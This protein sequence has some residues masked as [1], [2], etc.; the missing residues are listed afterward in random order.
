MAMYFMINS[1]K[2]ISSVYL[3]KW[4]GTSQ[5]TAWK[6]GH[7]VRAIMASQADA[8]PGLAGIV[9]LDEKYLGGKPRYQKDIKHK[10]GRGTAKSCV[11]VA[12]NRDGQVRASVVANDSYAELAPRVNRFIDTTAGLMSDQ[13]PVY[14][15]VA[16]DYA[17][18]ASVNHGAKEFVNGDVHNNTAESFNAILERVK[19]GVFH[20]LSK[21]H[22]QRYISEVVFRWNHRYPAKEISKNGV[23]KIIYKAKPILEQLQSLLMHAVGTQLRRST[24]GGI[25]IPKPAFRL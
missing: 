3:A 16:E 9:E 13:L 24:V 1:S 5:K 11:F 7:A 22:L 12:A 10:R 23:K 8:M 2:G 25:L 4:I 14:Q 20:F 6:V 17:S 21:L 18:H 15:K 19:Q